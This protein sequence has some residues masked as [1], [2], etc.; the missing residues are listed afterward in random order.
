MGGLVLFMFRSPKEL[1]TQVPGK[2]SN[3]SAQKEQKAL[4]LKEICNIP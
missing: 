3:S 2:E 4:T 1:N